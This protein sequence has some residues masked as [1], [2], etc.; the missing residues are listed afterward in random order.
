MAFETIIP[1]MKK[2]EKNKR[3]QL[4]HNGAY[5]PLQA[6]IDANI[7]G[8]FCFSIDREKRRVAIFRATDEAS[9]R[10]SSPDTSKRILFFG[11]KT[12][13]EEIEK[14]FPNL[15]LKNSTHLFDYHVELNHVWFE[16]E[17]PVETWNVKREK[18]GP[19]SLNE[20][21]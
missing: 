16:P 17:N 9:F 7:G 20:H 12:N 5:V 15:Y 8:D 1:K 13:I 3:I 21:K 6:V 10:V 4:S 14:E 18:K 19:F 11:S 2:T